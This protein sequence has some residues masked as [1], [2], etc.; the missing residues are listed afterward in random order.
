M[1]WRGN[2]TSNNIEDRRGTSARVMRGAGAGGALRLLPVV[3]R[4][5]GFKGTVILGLLIFGYLY[6]T[7]NLGLLVGQGVNLES[8]PTHQSQP[9]RQSAKE[10]ELVEFVS[11]VLADTEDTWGSLFQQMGTTYSPPKL[12]LYRQSVNSGCGFGSSQIGPF[13]CPVDQKVYID[14]SFYDDL[15]NRHGAPGDFAQAYVIAHEIGH[16]VQNLTG[17]AGKVRQEQKKLNKTASNKLS[18][19]QELQADCFAGLWAFH[20]NRSRNLLEA[21]DFEEGLVAA[22]AI[23]DDRLQKQ[24]HGH[25]VPDSFTHGSSA[26][27]V[28]WFK[29]GFQTGEFDACNTFKNE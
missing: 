6:F 21:G 24:T 7:D 9:V 15:K 29:K 18:V 12:V 2:R 8:E 28:D 13:Y 10:K 3:F 25:V 22:S 23:G 17:I 19:K 16:H 27:R 1:R 14:L 5:L 26:Q 20:A 11:V 4:V